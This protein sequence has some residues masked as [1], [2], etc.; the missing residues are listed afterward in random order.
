M[1]ALVDRTLPQKDKTASRVIDTRTIER[2]MKSLASVRDMREEMGYE[3][4]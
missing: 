2:M 3:S 1:R 4:R